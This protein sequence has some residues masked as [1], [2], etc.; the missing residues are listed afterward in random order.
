[1]FFSL[2]KGVDESRQFCRIL[3][4]VKDSMHHEAI[5]LNGEKNRE[6][7]PADQCPPK[8]LMMFG[9]EQGHLH[10][11]RNAC[12]NT[13][14][15]LQPQALALVLVLGEGQLQIVFG[16]FGIAEPH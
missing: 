15:K 8:R 11:R 14:E 10:D 9:K 6:W 5:L 1:M 13:I 4:V 16:P 3:S 7:K 2:C 12:L